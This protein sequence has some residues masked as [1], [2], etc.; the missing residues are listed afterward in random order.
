MRIVSDGFA[1]W[2]EADGEL[3]TNGRG[4]SRNRPKGCARSSPTFDS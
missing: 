1:A 2:V 3:E 4:K